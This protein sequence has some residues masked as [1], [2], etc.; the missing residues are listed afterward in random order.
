MA[1]ALQRLWYGD[2]TPALTADA[3]PRGLT[4]AALSLKAGRGI[5]TPRYE[6]WQDEAWA[7]WQELGELYYGVRWLS[8][9]LSRIRLVAAT[10]PEQPGDE[11]AMSEDAG[12]PVD[13][14]ARF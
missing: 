10:V 13:L 4:S 12:L 2:T 3:R 7:Y 8:E 9:M 14:V 1:G 5:I 6:R 11:P